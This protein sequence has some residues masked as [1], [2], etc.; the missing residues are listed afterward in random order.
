M[1]RS[2]FLPAIALLVAL[3]S[4]AAPAM[5]MAERPHA[6]LRGHGGG[7]SDHSC[8]KC[9]SDGGTKPTVVPEIDAGTG[10][11]SAAIVIAALALAWERRRR[12]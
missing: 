6:E 5:A 4:A 8:R 1:E 2:V 12:A 10:A 3:G 7:G 11:A 9:G